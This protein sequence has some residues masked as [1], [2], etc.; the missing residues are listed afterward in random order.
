MSL[1]KIAGSV[2]LTVIAIFL[3]VPCL[4]LDICLLRITTNTV[5]MFSTSKRCLQIEHL[6]N[7][8]LKN[9]IYQVLI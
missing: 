9:F 2:F 4:I 3:V 1:Y 7:R 6:L 8:D 5:F